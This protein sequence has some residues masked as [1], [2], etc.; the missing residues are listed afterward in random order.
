MKI[1]ILYDVIYPFS[2]GGGEK[3]NWEAARRLAARGHEVYLVSSKMWEGEPVLDREGVH[4]VGICRWLTTL[5]NL[6]N[7]SWMQPF[8]FALSAFIYL[9]KNKFDVVS[10]SAFPY[11]S[12]LTAKLAGWLNPAPLV[13][14]W[15]EARGYAGWKSYAG[16]FLGFCAAFLERWTALLSPHH[17]TISDYTAARMEKILAIPRQKITVIPCGVDIQDLQPKLPVP[18]EKTILYV[19][20]L[21]RHKRLDSLIDAFS[22]L[23]ADF[24]D[25]RVKIIGPGAEKA[26]LQEKAQANG[27]G[28]RIQFQDTLDTQALYEEFRKAAVFVLPSDQEGFGMVMIEAMA[29]GTPVIAKIAELSAA[30]TL[31]RHESTGL[32]FSTEAELAEC[33]RRVLTDETLRC[34]LITGGREEA[35]QYDWETSIIPKTEEYLEAVAGPG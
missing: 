32:L 12:C 31:I 20:R 15:Y 13:I 2:I 28:E 16:I 27:L 5:N 25:Y 21:V 7:R 22:L 10:C 29:A 3:I 14:T 6:G 17:I 35:K 11:L 34:R 9:R 24:P 19:G 30:S 4:C 8:L 1:A 23:A 33:I 26:S 18:K